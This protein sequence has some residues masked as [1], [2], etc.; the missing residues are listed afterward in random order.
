MGTPS[1]ARNFAGID[2][3]GSITVS[4]WAD[5]IWSSCAVKV[6][7]R[8]GG[9]MSFASLIFEVKETIDSRLLRNFVV[10]C[11]S[12]GIR[13]ASGLLG[14][15]P[16]AVTASLRSLELSLG[17]KLFERFGRRLELTDAGRLFAPEAR[18]LLRSMRRTRARLGFHGV[19]GGVV[20]RLAMDPIFLAHLGPALI[21]AFR[22]CY[23]ECRLLPV[24]MESRA[25]YDALVRGD[26][27]VVINC[28]DIGAR[29]V[30]SLDCMDLFDEEVPLCVHPEHPH[31]RFLPAP[32]GR[33]EGVVLLPPAGTDLRDRLNRIF[34]TNRWTP[35]R[36]ASV[37]D[38]LAARVL[39]ELGGA[40]ALLPSWSVA[41]RAML[42]NL[43]TVYSGCAPAR[44]RWQACHGRGDSAAIQAFREVLH[45]VVEDALGT[46]ALIPSSQ[47]R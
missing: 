6:A 32:G 34:S 42:G 39:V 17:V 8:L 12:G 4:P 21:Q 31:A 41:E 37:D 43:K 35:Q 2:F 15:Q 23:P 28:R 19:R 18:A 25:G 45:R 3:H 47:L 11:D 1:S 5:G 16:S 29:A 36:V 22:S 27:D 14:I 44:R 30:T 38:P 40:A 24:S 33:F 10:V 13:S 26:A 9:G 7:S 46:E 20:L